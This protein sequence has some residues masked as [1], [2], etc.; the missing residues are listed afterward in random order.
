MIT[1]THSLPVTRFGQGPLQ[2]SLTRRAWDTLKKPAVQ[3]GAL[4][5]G[6]NLSLPLLKAYVQC[7]AYQVEGLSP[8]QQ[9]VLNVREW[10]GAIVS[11]ATW[12]LVFFMSFLLLGRKTDAA[13]LKKVLLSTFCAS[14]VDIALRPWLTAKLLN[15]QPSLFKSPPTQREAFSPHKRVTLLPSDSQKGI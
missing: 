10:M 1:L 5:L 7:K 14:S 13:S 6:L 15:S 12:P 11:A 3:Q 2:R 9:R 8:G 4:L